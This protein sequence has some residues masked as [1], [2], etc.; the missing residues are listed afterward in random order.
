MFPVTYFTWS[1]ALPQAATPL[2]A[3][4][5]APVGGAWIVIW[6][7]IGQPS[8]LMDRQPYRA[9]VRGVT[10]TARNDADPLRTYTPS[11][12]RALNAGWKR[13]RSGSS[14]CH[15]LNSGR[16]FLAHSW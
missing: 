1:P 6:L 12:P 3:L 16:S 8:S 14:L 11:P 4:M 10:V 2:V 9:L 13:R 7:A 5:V 15:L